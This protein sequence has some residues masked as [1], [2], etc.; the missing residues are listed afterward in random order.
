MEMSR[1]KQVLHFYLCAATEI[2]TPEKKLKFFLKGLKI[3]ASVPA[4]GRLLPEWK[5]SIDGTS[6]KI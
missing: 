1:V 3:K 2:S 5:P 4:N 6:L